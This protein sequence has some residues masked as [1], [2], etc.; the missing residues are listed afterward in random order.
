MAP[1]RQPNRGLTVAA[2]G[3]TGGSARFLVHDGALGFTRIVRTAPGVCST[4][5]RSRCGPA[6]AVG[7]GSGMAVVCLISSMA[8]AELTSDSRTL[9]IS[10]L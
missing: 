10:A 8:K 9:R 2:D 7:L 1:F 6:Y 4:G 5:I 3:R